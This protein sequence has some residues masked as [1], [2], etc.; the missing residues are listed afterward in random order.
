MQQS[1]FIRERQIGEYLVTL[2]EP[3]PLKEIHN[4]GIKQADQKF[5]VI[6]PPRDYDFLSPEEQKKIQLQQWYF[7][8]N[9]LWFYNNGNIEYV[10]GLHWFYLTHWY[11]DTGLPKFIDADRDFFYLWHDSV[12]TINCFGLAAIENRRAGKTFRGTA[13][14]YEATSKTHEA[15]SGIQSKTDDD[16]GKV[17][18]KLIKCWKKLHD[19]FK[20]LDTGDTDPKSKLVFDEPAKRDTKS[21]RKKYRDALRSQIRF[22][23]SKETGFD[24][25]K[26]FR[27]FLDE[28]GKFSPQHNPVEIIRIVKETL[29]E[30]GIPKGKMYASTTVEEMSKRGGDKAKIIW[31]DSKPDDSIFGSQTGLRRYF[32]PCWYGY[33]GIDVSTKKMLVDEWGYTREKEAKE[34]FMKRRKAVEND[35]Q[36]Y[37]AEVQKYPFTVDEAF[38]IINEGSIFNLFNIAEQKAFIANSEKP[39]Y[40]RGDLG[41]KDGIVDSTVVWIPNKTGAFTVSKLP[42]EGQR[43]LFILKNGKKCPD[44]GEDGSDGVIGIDPVS[45][46]KTYSKRKSDLAAVGFDFFKPNDEFTH[47]PTFTYCCRK[48]TSIEMEEDMIMACIFWGVKAHIERNSRDLILK[49][50]SRGYQNY[51]MKR[52]DLSKSTGET[53]DDD[54]Y[55]T[56][57]ADPVWRNALVS[58]AKD[59]IQSYVGFKVI[60]DDYGKEI[61]TDIMGKVYLPELLTSFEDFIPSDDWTP[62]DLPVAFMYAVVCSKQY[63]TRRVVR[64][65]LFVIK[66]PTYKPKS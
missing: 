6:R 8:E 66:V 43:N 42:P 24:G 16:A 22:A 28:Y 25:D 23:S 13:I 44:R 63:V 62:Y 20:P 49:F 54:D 60:K 26:L 31:D 29:M 11:I 50:K 47:I 56:P 59:Y 61:K 9:G 55:G 39:L 52:M 7:R 5:P 65:E 2:P 4:Y 19:I 38:Y 21:Q 64:P 41:W 34:Y 37:R 33:Y 12:N 3:P 30:D 27:Y 35:L 45:L 57:N 53:K 1:N 51:L 15:D 17:F 48:P 18:G 32:K 36:A 14:L 10:T 58:A 46:L 40:V